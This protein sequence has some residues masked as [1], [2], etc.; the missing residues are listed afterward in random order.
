MIFGIFISGEGRE[1]SAAQVAAFE[2]TWSLLASLPR[3]CAA[4]AP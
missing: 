3:R 2:A 4:P 1:P